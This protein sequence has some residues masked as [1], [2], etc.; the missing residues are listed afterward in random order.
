MEDPRVFPDEDTIGLIMKAH[1]MITRENS[2]V[3][4]VVL[5]LS[6]N[7]GGADDA[8]I[9]AMAW[10][11]GEASISVTDNMTGAMCTTVYRAD[12]NR[13]RKFDEKDTVSDK[14]LF[15]LISPVSFS[16]G[17]LVPCI[18]KESGKVT[19]LGRTSGG[20]SCAVMNTSTAWGTAFQ[21]SS[22]QRMSFLKNGSFYDIDRGADPDFVLASPE[23]YYDRAA[24][25]EYLT[26]IR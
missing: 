17:N 26:S 10:F 22:N 24:L 23:R 2:P 7:L 8:A 18:F 13:D 4:N 1:A 14:H 19:L 25:T 3:E 12:V 15:C 20:G 6:A 11:L 16:C 9:F 5:D 21:I